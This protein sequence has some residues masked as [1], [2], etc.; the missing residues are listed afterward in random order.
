MP[1]VHVISGFLGAGKTT[2][3]KYLLQGREGRGRLAI[4]ENEFGQVGLDGTLLADQDFPVREINAGCICCTLAGDFKTDLQKLIDQYHPDE[5]IVEPSGVGRLSD[6]KQAVFALRKAK[7]KEEPKQWKSFLKRAFGQRNKAEKSEVN[8]LIPSVKKG[9]EV[10]LGALITVVDGKKCQ[11]YLQNFADFYRDQIAT[12]T[13]LLVTRTEMLTRDQKQILVHTLR[14]INP[15][16]RMH[17][18]SL[19][20]LDPVQWNAVLLDGQVS[21]PR[22]DWQEE[23]VNEAELEALRDQASLHESIAAMGYQSLAAQAGSEDSI[24]S[25]TVDAVSPVT[26]DETSLQIKGE[27]GSGDRLKSVVKQRLRADDVFQAQ[28][29]SLRYC[30]SATAEAL[31]VSLQ[32][33]SLGQ[34]VRFKGVCPM[35]TDAKGSWLHLEYAGGEWQ[36]KEISSRDRSLF[37]FIGTELNRQAIAAFFDAH[38]IQYVVVNKMDDLQAF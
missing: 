6:V 32:A 11:Q 24:S 17:L 29:Y 3:I 4:I 26:E 12:A 31:R 16:A 33:G 38:D 35:T 21:Q 15:Q 7:L 14:S 22:S 13:E 28:G 1:K 2:L 30:S 8:A 27:R 25:L 36:K 19:T 20:K 34:I 5:M 18:L 9:E 23:I 10:Q 37:I